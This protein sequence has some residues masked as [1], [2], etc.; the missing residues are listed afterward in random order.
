MVPVFAQTPRYLINSPDASLIID[1]P[2]LMI[3]GLFFMIGWWLRWRSNLLNVFARRWKVF[4]PLSILATTFALFLE[5][6]RITVGD[7][8]SIKWMA[9][10]LNA[11]TM[12]LAVIGWTGLFVAFFSQQSNKMR[13]LADS[14]LGIPLTCRLC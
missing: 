12:S 10:F 11:F 2:A 4:L 8:V 13:Y 6:Q 14:L 1:F 5:V 7:S 9:S 3:Y